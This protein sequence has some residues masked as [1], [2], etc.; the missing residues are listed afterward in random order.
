MS[1]AN[2][3]MFTGHLSS[4]D[5][6][7][8][9]AAAHALVYASLFEGFGIPIVEAF[10]AE[11]AVITSNVTS[12]PEVAG[13]AALLVDP[14]SVEQIADAMCRLAE[15]DVLRNQLIEKGRLQRQRFSWDRSAELLW[16]CIEKL[17]N[18][19]NINH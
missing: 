8:V 19:L 10:Y 3:V 16:N 15:D 12:M 6:A 1:C 18:Q 14:L 2:E 13:D 11:T 7:E 5:L 4:K 9:T 17:S